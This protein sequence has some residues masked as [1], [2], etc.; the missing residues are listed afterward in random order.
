VLQA[1]ITHSAFG[2][3]LCVEYECYTIILVNFPSS[4]LGEESLQNIST[5]WNLQRRVMV[6]PIFIAHNP[7]ISPQDLLNHLSALGIN[8]AARSYRIELMSEK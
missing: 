5:F 8:T 3:F 1:R 6:S 2:K 7:Q 4:S